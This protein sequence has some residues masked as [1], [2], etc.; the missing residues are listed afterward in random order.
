MMEIKTV[1]KIVL[2]W[3]CMLLVALP[4]AAQG[5][6]DNEEAPDF[7]FGMLLVGPRDDGGWSQAHYESGL[8]VEEELNAEMLLHENIGN[9]LESISDVVQQMVADDAEILFFTSASL[10]ASALELAAEYPDVTFIQIAGD[11]VLTGGAP[12]NYSNLMA[13]ME[14]GMFGLGCAAALTTETGN[15]GYL[16]P[17]INSETRRLAASA[18]LGADHCFE[19]FRAD[20]LNALNFRVEWVGFWFYIPGET[21]NPSRLVLSMFNDGYDVVLSGIDTPEALTVANR[22]RSEGQLVYASA[23]DTS[24]PCREYS[25][26]CI[27]SAVYSWHQQYISIIEEVRAGTWTSTWEWIP[28]RWER[29]GLEGESPVS[30]VVGGAFP[31]GNRTQLREFM[32]SIEDYATNELVPAS[33]PL[34]QGLIRLQ[35]GTIFANEDELVNILDVWYLPQLLD[36]M[37]GASF[38]FQ[39]E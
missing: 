5:D 18:Y 37:E 13:Q 8:I 16:G 6:D 22:L 31:V 27:G 12:P 29:F 10:E 36:G 34:W 25:G 4:V 26:V 19:Q 38:P 17:L 20:D 32:F 11:A 15:I 21:R 35:D 24:Q 23:Y 1:R 7:T 30:F 14:W 3:L 39:L 28:P 33:F 9:D 2:V